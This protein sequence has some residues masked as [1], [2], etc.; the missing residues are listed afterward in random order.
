MEL[1]QTPSWRFSTFF[2]RREVYERYGTFD[3]NFPRAADPSPM[4]I[5]CLR[6]RGLYNHI[7]RVPVHRATGGQKGDE[8]VGNVGRANPLEKRDAGTTPDSKT[9]ETGYSSVLKDNRIK[10]GRGFLFWSS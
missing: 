7:H 3:L 1:A 4:C 5:F 10:K 9:L 8:S 2:V 6:N